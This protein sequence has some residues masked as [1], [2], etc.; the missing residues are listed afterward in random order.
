ME[1]ST[2]PDG[3]AAQFEK[4]K[5]SNK[6]ILCLDSDGHKK[7]AFDLNAMLLSHRGFD[8]SEQWLFHGADPT[9]A[10]LIVQNGF[11]NAGT[12]NGKSFGDGV[13]FARDINYS[14][15][16]TYSRPDASGQRVI[17]VSRVLVGKRENT[18]SRTRMLSSGCRS[19]GDSSGAVVMKPYANLSDVQ[20][21]VCTHSCFF[22][23]RLKEY[24]L[25][26]TAHLL[27]NLILLLFI[28][29]RYVGI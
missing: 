5:A 17:L 16:R 29:K 15:Q 25:E 9:A 1:K 2:L 21:T 22:I 8:T 12:K 4:I 6:H 18:S 23:E 19:G 11:Q 24:F 14:L 20:I 28:Y 27:N 26:A 10:A 3:L 13:Y 7:Q